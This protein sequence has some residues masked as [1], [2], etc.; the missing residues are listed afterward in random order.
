MRELFMEG[1]KLIPSSVGVMHAHPGRVR[2]KMPQIKK[3][4]G[5]G[6]K[7]EQLL[8]PVPGIKK[9]QTN[10]LTG[11]LLVLYDPERIG[12]PEAL[13][14]LEP[15]AESLAPYFPDLDLKRLAGWLARLNHQLK[16]SRDSDGSSSVGEPR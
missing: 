2:L 10:P 12:S 4:P 13:E 14:A 16:G 9:V 3:D 15:V 1:R 11:S 7:V 5:F 8:S 6:G